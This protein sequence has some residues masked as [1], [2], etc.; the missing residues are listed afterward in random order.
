[1]CTQGVNLTQFKLSLHQLEEGVKV[2][3]KSVEQWKDLLSRL[4]FPEISSNLKE[5]EE[6]LERAR[7]KLN[8]TL[9]ETSELE[10][11]HEEDVE[12]TPM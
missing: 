3:K 4:N 8:E 1:M 11:K 5:C 10:H 12:I 2:Y 9:K 6:L 7:V